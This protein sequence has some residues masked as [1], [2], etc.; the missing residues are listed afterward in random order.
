MSDTSTYS[1]V[2]EGVEH[3]VDDFCTPSTTYTFGEADLVYKP[4]FYTTLYIILAYYDSTV[5]TAHNRG[6][7][8]FKLIYLTG[9]KV[10]AAAFSIFTSFKFREEF[11]A[12]IKILTDRTL[13][14][15]SE[16]NTQ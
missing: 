7:H 8:N 14:K 16:S 15:I 2:S 1:L 9:F 11:Y 3:C 12:E 6:F 4:E 5:Y 13:S 10:F